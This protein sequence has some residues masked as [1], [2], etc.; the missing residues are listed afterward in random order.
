MEE[1]GSFETVSTG[2]EGFT[3]LKT[4]NHKSHKETVFKFRQVVMRFR[5]VTALLI[6]AAVFV[7]KSAP[8]FVPL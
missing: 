7:D 1:A 8:H 6:G 3:S 4:V 2:L 5:G